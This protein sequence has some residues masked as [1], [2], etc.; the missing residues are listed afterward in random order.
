MI[1]ND[2][3]A[4]SLFFLR[5]SGRYHSAPQR[6]SRLRAGRRHIWPYGAASSNASYSLQV[7]C[8]SFLSAGRGWVALWPLWVVQRKN[9]PFLIIPD[10]LVFV[11]RD[12]HNFA[13]AISTTGRIA[14]IIDLGPLEHPR[15]LLHFLFAR[16]IKDIE[17]VRCIKASCCY[18]G[19]ALSDVKEFL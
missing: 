7:S 19:N 16:Q 3:L 2:C 6:L 10:G 9:P 18:N 14:D 12:F 8:R 15:C 11:A 5:I 17:I 13:I 4:F 1:G